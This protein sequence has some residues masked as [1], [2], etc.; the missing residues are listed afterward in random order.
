MNSS[1]GWTKRPNTS[2]DRVVLY[3]G[4]LIDQGKKSTTV[5]PYVSA[6][7]SVLMD[8][9][10]ILN[11]NKYLLTSITKACKLINDKVRTRLPIQSGM[12]KLILKQIDREYDTQ[13]YLK[14]LFKAM[15]AASYFGLLRVGEVTLSQHVIKARDVHIGMNKNKILFILRS[16]KTHG[17]DSKPQIVKISGKPIPIKGSYVTRGQAGAF[18]IDMCPFVILQAFASR[19]PDEEEFNEQFFVFADNS[20]V[21]PTQM[22][23]MLKSM[24]SKAGFDSNLYDTHILHIGRASD[25]LKLQF[26]VETIKKIG[27]WR[28]SAIY[29]Y[30]RN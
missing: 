23:T 2:K 24:I 4:F 16:S 27:R 11:E 30:L 17:E 29:T 13:C 18:N 19:R 26:S 1:S 21:K 14:A 3:A 9:E 7:R 5:R 28:S 25:L 10:V 6:I 8:D 22:H 15:V 20:P 12:L